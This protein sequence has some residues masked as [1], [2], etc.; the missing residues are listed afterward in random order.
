M[1]K[2]HNI[3]QTNFEVEILNKKEFLKEL[4]THD[5]QKKRIEKIKDSNKVRNNVIKGS[6]IYNYEY[7]KEFYLVE[8][9]AANDLYNQN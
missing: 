6:K 8:P 9:Q 3:C 2:N 1:Y 7:S 5:K 4:E